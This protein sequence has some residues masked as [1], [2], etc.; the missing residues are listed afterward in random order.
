VEDDV[1]TEQ[2]GGDPAVLTERGRRTKSRLRDAAR[3]VFA[4]I[5][6]VNARVEDIVVRA[7]VSHGTFYT[8]YDNKAAILEELV[9]EAAAELQ[10]VVEDPWEGPDARS[11]LERVIG[12]FLAVYGAEADVFGAWVEASAVDPGF[13]A[14][15]AETRGEF[16]DRVAEN[17]AP[18]VAAGG[19][20]PHT[21]SKALVGMIEGFVTEH[22]EDVRD[23]P[24]E[25]VRTLATI[26]YGG[27]MALADAE[28]PERA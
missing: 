17:L 2:P 10:A 4:D 7:D 23:S 1:P 5:G 18:V 13:A 20:A 25:L 22:P 24:A 21:A 26:W 19:H 14:L 12:D 6:Y 3:R 11:A 15:L 28:I 9:R 8:Y 16:I 27:L